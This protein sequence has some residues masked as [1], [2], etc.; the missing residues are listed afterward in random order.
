MMS[1]NKELTFPYAITSTTKVY[2]IT[3]KIE[4]EREKLP[5]L[6]PYNRVQI[7]LVYFEQN[8]SSTILELSG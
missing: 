6:Y 1:S 3:I 8:V 4:E 2:P 7:C 5:T